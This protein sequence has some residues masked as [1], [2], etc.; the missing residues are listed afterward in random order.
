MD[1]PVA[2][3][4]QPEVMAAI[5]LGLLILAFFF[6][7]PSAVKY[8]LHGYQIDYL[9]TLARA[10]ALDSPAA[11]LQHIVDAV[12][13]SDAKRDAAFNAVHCVHCGSV[14]PAEWIASRKGQKDE[15]ALAISGAAK[16]FLASEIVATVGKVGA[17]PKKV[18]VAEKGL[19]SDPG[20]AARVCIDWAIKVCG[21]DGTKDL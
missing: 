19:R 1:D 21:A 8:A 2:F 17:P 15:H 13:G 14:S 12:M 7:R 20:K 5:G 3:L 10:K 16:A 11:A 9:G 6:A 18:I 4:S